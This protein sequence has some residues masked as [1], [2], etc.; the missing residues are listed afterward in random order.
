MSLDREAVFVSPLDLN[1]EHDEIERPLKPVIRFATPVF[2]KSDRKRG[3]L[4]LNYLGQPLIRKLAQVSGGFR[5]ESWLLN[6][7]GFFLRGPS[8]EDEWGFMLGHD[9]RFASYYPDEWSTLG[10]W[11]SPGQIQTADGLFSFRTIFPGGE[12]PAKPSAKPA[13]KGDPDLADAGL[14]VVS[15]LSPSV[16]NE[17][18]DSLLRRLLLL[19][20][21]VLLLL[22]IV[23]WYLAR[24]GA[25]R[26]K[27]EQHLTESETRLRT[28][29]TQLITAQEDERRRLSR[30]LHD[31]MG[32][33]VTAVTLDLQRAAQAADSTKKDGLIYMALLG[34]NC[35][36]DKIHEISLRIRPTLLDDLGLKDAVQSLL[37]DY[38]RR[39]GIVSRAE[40]EFDHSK[41]P[42]PISENVFRILQEALT[43]VTKH[44]QTKEVSV[45]LRVSE[46]RVSL[47]VRDGGVGFAPEKVNGKGLGLLG[48]RERAEL[49]NGDFHMHAEAG[50]GTE[51]S[52]SIPF[53]SGEGDQS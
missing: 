39:T 24:A 4:V 33:V 5:G 42:A 43:N 50:K 36:L 21:V 10:G 27:Q 53:K 49:L 31:E 44:A 20:G 23:S 40:L 8:P 35:L 28:L 26:R 25:L 52:V 41:V 3:V 11:S 46:G 32:Q 2:D 51:I 15:H 22:L 19:G 1:V 48:M 16:L 14:I 7:D 17:R 13:D 9:R 6:R 45:K 18:A 29:S 37:S 38:E 30:D 12:A 34:A 47:T